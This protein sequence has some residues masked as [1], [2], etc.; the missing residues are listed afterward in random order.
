MSVIDLD[1]LEKVAATPERAA[2]W[3]Q[4]ALRR[5]DELTI[6]LTRLDGPQLTAQQA[7]VTDLPR[8][9]ADAHKTAANGP[10]NPLRWWSGST[11]EHVWRNLRDVEEELIDIVDAQELDARAASARGYA[12]SHRVAD[13]DPAV[14]HLDAS[15]ALAFHRAT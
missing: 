1:L 8:R 15:K 2:A 5:C 12:R 4:V 6:E 7:E 11:V 9:L 3:R 10:V 13:D 14:Q